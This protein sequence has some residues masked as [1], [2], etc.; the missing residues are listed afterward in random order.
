MFPSVNYMPIARQACLAV[1]LFLLPD[2]QGFHFNLGFPLKE[3]AFRVAADFLEL[4]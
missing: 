3:F 1:G 4:T 2:L